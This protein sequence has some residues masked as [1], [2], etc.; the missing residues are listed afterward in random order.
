MSVSVS[1]SEPS[2]FGGGRRRKGVG[3]KVGQVETRDEL[4]VN[5]S[6]ATT[7][8]QNSWRAIEFLLGYN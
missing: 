3:G 5:R 1:I 7:S 4:Q 6:P 2:R 8:E